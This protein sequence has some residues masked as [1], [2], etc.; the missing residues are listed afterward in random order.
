MKGL[1]RFSRGVSF[2]R[3]TDTIAV[4]DQITLNLVQFTHDYFDYFL[5]CTSQVMNLSRTFVKN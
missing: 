5:L 3:E 2:L 1:H 4:D